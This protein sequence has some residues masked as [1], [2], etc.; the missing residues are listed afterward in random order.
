MNGK[1]HSLPSLV[2]QS[3]I[4]R[5]NMTELGSNPF[6]LRIQYFFPF[7]KYCTFNKNLSYCFSYCQSRP[8]RFQGRC[9]LRRRS[10]T[11]QS[12]SSPAI[13]IIECQEIRSR[14]RYVNVTNQGV[15]VSELVP[16]DAGG[17]HVGVRRHVGVAQRLV[18]V[19]VE[20]DALSVAGPPI[21]R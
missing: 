10:R 4:S 19:V 6:I 11:G 13:F 3:I 18:H 20:V 8:P 12:C 5:K 21:S 15:R 17:G 14:L 1:T 2:P 9:S 16:D 7:K